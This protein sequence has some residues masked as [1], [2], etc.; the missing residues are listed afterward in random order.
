MHAN[1]REEID[2]A[3]AGEIVAFGR[4]TGKRVQDILCVTKAHQL[5]SSLLRFQNQLS[6]WLLSQKPNKIRKKM[7]LA[8]E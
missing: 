7:G 1:K 4:I 3:Y 6:R 8:F 2:A 5:Y